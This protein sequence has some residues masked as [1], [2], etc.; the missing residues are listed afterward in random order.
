MNSTVPFHYNQTLILS[1][2]PFDIYHPSYNMTGSNTDDLLV[3]LLGRLGVSNK[4]HVPTVDN[5]SNITSSTNSNTTPNE[6]TLPH[7]FTVGTLHDPTSGAWNKDTGF[8]NASELLRCDS[9]GDLYPVT[10]PSPI[11]HAFLVSQHTWHQHLGHPGGDVLRRLVSS[12]FISYNKEKPPVLCH[13]CQLGKHVRL[14]FVS[15]STVIRS[16]FDGTDTAYLLLYV[17][18]IILIASAESLLAH[19]DN[20]NPSRTPID[21]ESKLGSDGDPVSEPTLYQSLAGSFTRPDISYAV[22]QIWLLIQMQL[23]LVVLLL[24]A[25][26]QV[27]HFKKGIAKYAKV[28]STPQKCLDLDSSYFIQEI[29]LL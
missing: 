8:H 12:N 15:S 26:L 10:A 4:H 5:T 25:L 20:C 2:V 11:P 23:G 9:T 6:T 24:D 7:A 14:L 16:Y 13:V 22:Q 17:D 18:D 19:M 3:K 29:I 21:T 1:S 28:S 27:I